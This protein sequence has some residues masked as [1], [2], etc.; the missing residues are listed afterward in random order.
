[1]RNARILA[2]LAALA[3]VRWSAR[4]PDLETAPTTA[5]I[6]AHHWTTK[7]RHRTSQGVVAYDQCNCGRWRVQRETTALARQTLAVT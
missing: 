2:A 5:R 1:M 3:P 4:H 6:H 7:S